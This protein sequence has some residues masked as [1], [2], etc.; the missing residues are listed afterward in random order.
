MRSSRGKIEISQIALYTVS[1]EFGNDISDVKYNRTKEKKTLI[2]FT[3][4]VF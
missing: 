3:R 4:V 1:R 2:I